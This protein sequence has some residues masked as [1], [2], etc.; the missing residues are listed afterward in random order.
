MIKENEG[1]VKK[2]K[3][4]TSSPEEIIQSLKEVGCVKKHSNSIYGIC[5]SPDNKYFVTG[6]VDKSIIISDIENLADIKK[7]TFE[8]E[9][10]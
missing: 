9:V 8:T 2:L 1:H 7:K 10:R 3:Q 5:I 4:V 6:S